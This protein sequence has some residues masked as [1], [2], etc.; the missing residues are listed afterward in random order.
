MAIIVLLF[1]DLGRI[2]AELG[3]QNNAYL[4]KTIWIELEGRKEKNR[5]QA[6]ILKLIFPTMKMNSYYLWIWNSNTIFK[7]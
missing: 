2:V 6:V 3:L 1:T 5:L 4:K 7:F